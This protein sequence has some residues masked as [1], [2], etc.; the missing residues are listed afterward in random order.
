MTKLWPRTR[1]NKYSLP[2]IFISKCIK[3]Y[4]WLQNLIQSVEWYHDRSLFLSEQFGCS[5]KLSH[6]HKRFGYIS[7][8]FLNVDQES[9]AIMLHVLHYYLLSL[10]MARSPKSSEIFNCLLC[11][12]STSITRSF[13]GQFW[14]FNKV[15]T[16]VGERGQHRKG[17]K[18]YTTA[19]SM[20]KPQ[21]NHLNKQLIHTL[22]QWGFVLILLKI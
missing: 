3:D 15:L 7:M 8:L 9:Q 20:H 10:G 21:N 4:L 12:N 5:H 18:R 22:I 11:N 17:V 19:A 1:Y 6:G 2:S 14:Q 16:K 13:K